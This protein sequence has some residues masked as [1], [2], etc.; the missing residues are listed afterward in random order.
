MAPSIRT[1]CRF[2][3]SMVIIKRVVSSISF[4]HSVKFAIGEEITHA[5][6]YTEVK[7]ENSKCYR[8]TLP[9]FDENEELDY[10]KSI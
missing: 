1:V 7:R 9:S 4:S 10:S 6:N 2:K 5:V 3:F 8:K